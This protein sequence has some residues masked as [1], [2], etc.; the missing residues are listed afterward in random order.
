MPDW[1]RLGLLPYIESRR[2]A[3]ELAEA[4]K[5]KGEKWL[6]L[7]LLTCS[8]RKQ[9]ETVGST[10]TKEQWYSHRGNARVERYRP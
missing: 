6:L 10:T 2:V 1:S 9:T 5:F 3:V 7:L 8:K 4:G